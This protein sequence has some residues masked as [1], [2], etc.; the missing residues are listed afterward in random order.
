MNSSLVCTAV[1]DIVPEGATGFLSAPLI[2]RPFRK[3]TPSPHLGC[4]FVAGGSVRIGEHKH[5]CFQPK[6]A[7]LGKRKH[8]EALMQA[9]RESGLKDLCTHQI[10]MTI[11]VVVETFQS[12]AWC[13]SCCRCGEPS[14]WLLALFHLGERMP[15]AD[16]SVSGE[17]R[18]NQQHCGFPSANFHFSLASKLLLPCR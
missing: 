14:I 5:G 10:L 18:E 4:C 15:P 12:P 3:A 13:P 6:E 11:Y 9:S 2:H 8:P 16:L 17:Q 7:Q 1:R